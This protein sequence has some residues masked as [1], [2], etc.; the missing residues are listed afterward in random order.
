MSYL[1]P[2]SMEYFIFWTTIF[3]VFQWLK[4]LSFILFKEKSNIVISLNGKITTVKMSGGIK[5]IIAFAS[6]IIFFIPFINIFYGFFCL[7]IIAKHY[8]DNINKILKLK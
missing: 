6:L 4:Y 5:L 1:L 8:L 3:L 2:V 7:S